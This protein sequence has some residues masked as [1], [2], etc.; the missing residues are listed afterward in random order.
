MSK[1]PTI[2]GSGPI[3]AKVEQDAGDSTPKSIDSEEHSATALE[4]QSSRLPRSRLVLICASLMVALF[5]TAFEQTSVST[6]LPAI[7]NELGSA[8][9][10]A[11]IGTAYLIGSTASQAVFTRLSDIFGRMPM[12][13]VGIGLFFLG[14]LLC[15]FA[16]SMGQL[17]AF[18]GIAGFG[19]GG[20]LVCVMV[21][22]SDIV[23][24]RNRGK[25]QAV[26]GTA[27]IVAN[28]I[29]P[30]LGGVFAE[31]NWRW[32]FWVVCPP[33]AFAFIQTWF[34]HPLKPVIAK[35]KTKIG[36]IDYLG[37]FCQIASVIFL[38]I[39][40]SGAG[41]SFAWNSAKAIAF[42][43]IG[44]LFFIAFLIVEGFYAKIPIV[45]LHLFKNRSLS[46]LFFST[47]C[48]GAYYF[49][50]VYYLP[51]FFQSVRNETPL[52]SSLLL[53]ALIL[54]QVVTI[55][56]AGF[57]LTRYGRYNPLLWTGYAIYLIGAGLQTRFEAST[58]QVYI[59]G[60]LI[61]EGFGMGWTLQTS[62]VAIQAIA[63]HEDRA[64]ATGVRNSARF[65]GGSFGLAICSNILGNPLHHSTVATAPAAAL[66][67][68][69]LM[70]ANLVQENAC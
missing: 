13:M 69:H 40:I 31:A 64:V 52:A 28:G 34:W 50:A 9:S 38:L 25:I 27:V 58:S 67:L 56:V 66:N 48:T 61:V 24:L 26:M 70:P 46:L 18:R 19:G 2:I 43:A 12:Y 6:G 47:F 49:S 8:D 54:T 32:I 5:L 68:D 42:L 57:V 59:I 14:S 11:W 7:S 1:N 41:S 22:M 44:V 65:I 3:I 21:I 29:A 23:S 10:R 51:A 15:G 62:L 36:Q 60:I 17:I 45:P 4:D 35:T 16:K 63:T 37:M 33:A 39:P 55:L 53:L 30:T 20:I